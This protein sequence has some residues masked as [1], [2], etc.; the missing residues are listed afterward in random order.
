MILIF[1]FIIIFCALAYSAS[2]TY[3]YKYRG[4]AR[5]D[6]LTQ[7]FRKAWPV[8]APFNCLLYIFT[9][10]RACK[11][12]M[13]TKDFSELDA[14]QENWEVIRDEA[15]ALLDSGLFDNTKD[16]E[17]DAYY[18]IGFR[19][20]YKYGWSKFYLKWY[21]HTQKSALKLCPKTSALLAK[22]PSVNGA[23]FST[24]PPEGKLTKHIDPVA[25]S[26]RYHLGLATPNSKD[27]YISVDDETYSWKDGEAFIF[28]ETYIHFVNN[29]T[30]KNRLILMCDIDRPTN[31]IGSI[32]N[33]PIKFLMG[34][35]SLVPNMPGD[36]RGIANLIFSNITPFLRSLKKLKESN[37][38][39]Y[40]LVKNTI[41]VSLVLLALLALAAVVYFV[42]KLISGM[43]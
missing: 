30:D 43:N 32:I 17:S 18:D 25:S 4:T 40:I 26:L 6:S 41:N 34:I 27:C 39:L 33:A 42:S 2:M 10:K 20:F 13:D 11:P 35:V 3:V 16:P 8:F 19:S 31:W 1:S 28:D 21:G 36:N 14:I 15:Q 23:M 29:N 9:E 24:L 38:P 5:Y 37:R 22:I 12:I 7:Y